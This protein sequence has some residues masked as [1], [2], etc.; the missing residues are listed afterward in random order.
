MSDVGKKKVQSANVEDKD[1]ANIKMYNEL[2]EKPSNKLFVKRLSL[3][4]VFINIWI[5]AFRVM[6]THDT[7]RCKVSKAN[8]AEM[9][10]IKLKYSYST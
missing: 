7:S 9:L 2:L 3:V 1:I 8:Y 5:V 10:G 6:Y 4:I